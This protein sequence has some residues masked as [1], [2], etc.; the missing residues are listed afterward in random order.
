MSLNINKNQYES[1]KIFNMLKKKNCITT[2][3]LEKIYRIVEENL[4]T[5]KKHEQMDNLNI[6]NNKQTKYEITKHGF[7]MILFEI[8]KLNSFGQ[9]GT[10]TNYGFNSNDD[11]IMCMCEELVENS[12][13]AFILHCD[14]SNYHSE[15]IDKYFEFE[16]EE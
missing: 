6:F 1:Y 4:T 11:L 5:I 2:K 13:R 8:A 16:E 10:Q 15:I 14:Y 9:D 12:K 3:Q 7:N